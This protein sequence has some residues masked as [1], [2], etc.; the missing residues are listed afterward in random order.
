M[1]FSDIICFAKDWNEPKT[2]NNHVMEELARCGHRVLWVNPLPMRNPSFGSVH[3]RKKILRK[4]RGWF[5]GVERISENLRVVHPVLVPLPRVGW[6]QWVNRRLVTWLVRRAARRWGFQQPQIWVFPPNAV[7]FIGQ[8]DE[9]KVVYYCTD[10]WSQFHY[11]N[12]E[13]MCQKEAKLLKRA[14][15]VFVT[16]Q[17]LLDSKRPANP[18]TYLMPHGV[19]H[20]LFAQ[21]LRDDY[22]VADELRHLPH[23]LIGFYGNIYDWVDQELIAALATA[24]PQW[25]FVLVGKVMTEVSLL[26][27]CPNI[28]L[29]G[30]RAYEDLPRFCKGFDVGIIPYKTTDPRIQTVNPLKL[31]EYLAAGIPVVSVDIPEAR[32]FADRISIASDTESFLRALTTLT[33]D[34]A[35]P[36][37]ARSD[38]MRS[39]TWVAR[40]AEMERIIASHA[41]RQVTS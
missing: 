7:D 28:H 34:T 15:V 20:S 11:I 17:K 18:A 13:F 30:R 4:L 31:R 2:S 14:D 36:R 37:Q 35:A 9:S 41:A 3:D 24:R 1:A 22:P 32:F 23:P 33:D 38:S 16:S 27:Q 19:N 40:V 5:R 21:A 39:E 8:F 26:Q 10:E 6:A 29:T 25:S 12:A